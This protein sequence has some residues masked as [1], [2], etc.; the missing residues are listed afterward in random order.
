MSKPIPYP[1]RIEW[2]PPSERTAWYG[3]PIGNH[4]AFIYDA[5][6]LWAYSCLFEV[7]LGSFR[8]TGDASGFDESKRCAEAAFRKLIELNNELSG[9]G[10]G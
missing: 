8:L 9:G 1:E 3:L 10:N 4:D 2:A 6:G 5:A 7:E